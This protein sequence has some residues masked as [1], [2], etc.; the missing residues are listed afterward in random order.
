MTASYAKIQ[1]KLYLKETAQIHAFL[2]APENDELLSMYESVVEE[3]QFKI[4]AKRKDYQNFDEVM[5]YL[6]EL[7]FNRDAV[8][9]Q[10][11][12][13]RLTRAVL[14]YMYWNCDIG[15][16]GDAKTEQTLPS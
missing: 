9:R 6:L 11:P 7:L 4:F 1:Q 8:L 14:F 3:F 16:D 2:A 10:R 12:H 13:K 15:E 5:E